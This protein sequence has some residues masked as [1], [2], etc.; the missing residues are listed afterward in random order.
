MVKNH[1]AIRRFIKININYMSEE[2][3][4]YVK[5]KGIVKRIKN[6]KGVLNNQK[7]EVVASVLTNVIGEKGRN[8]Y[9]SLLE[10]IPKDNFDKL[11]EVYTKLL[12]VSFEPGKF[13]IP[14]LEDYFELDKNELASFD[15]RDEEEVDIGVEE[16]DLTQ[17]KIDKIVYNWTDLEE[18]DTTCDFL[19]DGF[20]PRMG[21][22]LLAGVPDSGKSML[23][24]QF[25]L[26]LCG[27]KS[28]FI[29]LQ[30]NAIRKTAIYVITEDSPFKTKE[31]AIKQAEG[32]GINISDNFILID[33]SSLSP[34][35][36]INQI[37]EV[38]QTNLPDII[39]VDA[40]GDAYFGENMNDNMQG[41]R[42]VKEYNNIAKEFNC[43]V[44][45]VHH[46]NKSGYNSPPSQKDIQGASGIVQK[47]RTGMILYKAKDGYRYLYVGKGNYTD[48]KYKRNA[49]QLSFDSKSLLF[50][51]TDELMPLNKLN[52]S[53]SKD[54]QTIAE[55]AFKG[56]SELRHKDLL[57][58]LKNQCYIGDTAAKSYIQTMLSLYIIYKPDKHYKLK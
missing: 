58:K 44:L 4:D 33:G 10:G 38:C 53:N 43:F 14:F 25:C 39:V 35:N 15:I 52:S 18:L 57:D 34:S 6:E 8:I 41:R 49:F 36:I 40:L 5:L 48:D 21:V 24:R 51:Y 37:I 42:T 2:L 1:Y 26:S 50:N 9:H 27:G 46:V 12:F 28:S 20:F 32:L 23:V 56:V 13:K 45:F 22:G 3:N 29:D 16:C 55:K 30:I 31:S 47:I 19:L 11:D 17:N 7:L 54:Y